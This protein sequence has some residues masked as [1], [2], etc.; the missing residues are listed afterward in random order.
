MTVKKLLACLLVCGLGAVGCQGT[1]T[2]SG[3]KPKP[4]TTAATTKVEMEKSA[5]TGDDKVKTE[6]KVETKVEDKGKAPP[7]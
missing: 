3:T 1:T 2:S 4:P 6:T 7:P 5:P